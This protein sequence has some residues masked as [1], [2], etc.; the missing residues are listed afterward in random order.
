MLIREGS[1]ARNLDAIIKGFIANNIALDNCMFCT[2]DKHLEDIEKEGHIDLCVKKAIALGVPVAT[3]YKMASYNAARAYQLYDLGAVAAGYLADLL[4]IDDV[5][6]VTIEQVIKNGEIIDFDTLHQKNNTPVT[7][8]DLLHSVKLPFIN[9][10]KIALQVDNRPVKVIN[11][12]A[13]SILTRESEEILPVKDQFFQANKIFNKACVIERHGHAGG[14]GVSAIKGY[15]IENGAIATSVSHDAH[16]ITVVGDND[17]D[18]LLAVAELDRIQGGYVI[19]SKG[20]IVATL[21][22]ELAGIISIRS[23]K[24]VQEQ[25]NKMVAH[26]RALGVPESVDPFMTLSFISLTVIPELRLTD[27]GLY[28]V[29][30]GQFI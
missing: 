22:L 4:I 14:I 8:T 23:A 21:P 28:D 19:A 27:N 25:L 5:E 12:V 1:A 29:D 17:E 2:D 9:Q 6:Q 13:H 20:K 15:N 18:I 24:F 30:H 7:D 16:N 26:A 11:L 3:A 10:D